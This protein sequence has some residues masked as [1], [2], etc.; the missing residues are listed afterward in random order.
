MRNERTANGCGHV[1]CRVRTLVVTLVMSTALPLFTTFIL[2]AIGHGEVVTG[3]VVTGDGAR[4]AV[5]TGEQLG[6]PNVPSVPVDRGAAG[7][8]GDDGDAPPA[9]A[10][11]R[12]AANGTEKNDDV[13]S[14]DRENDVFVPS[15]KIL[16]DSVVPFPVDI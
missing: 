3:D 8:A 13:G 7:D 5:Q 15:E 2:P 10:I 9:P 11:S 14:S 6:G 16:A 1:A 12:D 4:D